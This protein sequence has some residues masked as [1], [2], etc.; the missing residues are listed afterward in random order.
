MLLRS[1]MRHVRDQNWVAVGLDFL[2]V[3]VG[4]FI[5]IQVANWNEMRRERLE[6]QRILARLQVEVDAL[7]EVQRAELAETA[8]R[9]LL[10]IPV[11]PVLFGQ[12]PP[13]E[14]TG[15]ECGAI[16]SSHI[17]R[18]PTDQVPVLDEIRETGRFDL[19]RDPVLKRSLRN[20]I[21][22]QERTRGHYDELSN[23]LFRLHSRHPDVIAVERAP[24]DPDTKEDWA[25]LSGEGF[26]WKPICSVEEMQASPGFLND[27]VDNM[28]RTDSFLRMYEARIEALES[29]RELLRTGSSEPAASREKT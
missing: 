19:I 12:E 9:A 7:I 17:Y 24:L 11:Q 21:L 14:L 2:I 27:Y 8:E 20:Y 3:V 29:L 4:V 18:R 15:D 6:E 23:E 13:R 25:A 28:S 22:V 5:G 26:R 16:V 10:L 1:V